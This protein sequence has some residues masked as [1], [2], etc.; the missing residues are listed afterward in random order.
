MMST[1]DEW[2][3]TDRYTAPEILAEGARHSKETDVFAFGMVTILVGGDGP[4]PCQITL[5]VDEGFH[6]RSSV[7]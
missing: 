2:G 3:I 1:A 6:R 4:A 5:P 7:Q